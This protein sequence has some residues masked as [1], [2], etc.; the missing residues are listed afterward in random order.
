MKSLL[1]FFESSITGLDIGTYSA[2]IVEILSN[3]RSVEVTAVCE[4]AFDRSASIDEN[5]AEL[6]AFMAREEIATEKLVTALPGNRLTQRHLKFP[7]VGK[8]V[9][10]AVPIELAEELPIPLDG[11]VLNQEHLARRQP[12]DRTD[13]LAVLA[14]LD[15]VASHIEQL[16]TSGCDPAIVEVEGAVLA[17]GIAFL[18]LDDSPRLVLD[19]GHRSTNVTLL[20]FGRPLMIRSIAVGGNHFT[21]AIAAELG[22][23]PAAAEKHKHENGVFRPG[24]ITPLNLRINGLLDQLIRETQRSVQ[25]IV[26]DNSLD[27]APSEVLLTGASAQL[28]R[29]DEFIRS[30]TRLEC[31]ILSPLPDIEGLGPLATIPHPERFIQ[32]LSLALRG[33]SAKRTRSD[34]RQG[35]LGYS[36]DFSALG[37]ELKRVAVLFGVVLALWPLGYVAEF[38][39]AN[40][41]L[42]ALENTMAA[43]YREAIP[44]QPVPADPM[45]ALQQ[46][47]GETEELANHL[48]LTGSGASPLELLRAIHEPLPDE[49][50]ISLQELRLEG[51]RMQ[52]TGFAPD[53]NEVSRFR[54]EL[55]KV[56]LFRDVSVSNVGKVR[57]QQGTRFQMTIELERQL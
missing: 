54:E 23:E 52:A 6:R 35:Q 15:E 2:K 4:F 47:L 10:E 40:R 45:S 5:L 25:A 21:E 16:R 55:A 20:A 49:L 12:A 1:S 30:K 46:R 17:N 27:L 3:P 39:A 56:P 33:S 43:I 32:A 41:R 48:G 11:M 22:L 42:G 31:R 57:S 28:P 13:V 44:D 51:T 18:G 36:A 9:A 8:Q 7:F 24:G 19:V 34:F 29:L 50:E 14:P 53:F 37:R 38:W 26:S